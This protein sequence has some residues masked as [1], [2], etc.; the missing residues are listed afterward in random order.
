MKSKSQSRREA[1]QKA[2]PNPSKAESKA[3]LK[4]TFGVPKKQK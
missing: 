1:V 3:N 4:T 2:S